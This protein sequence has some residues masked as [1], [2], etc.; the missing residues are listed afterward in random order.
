M[1]SQLGKDKRQDRAIIQ[2]QV[3]MLS[4]SDS[5]LDSDDGMTGPQEEWQQ[6][7]NM[8]IHG[9]SKSFFHEI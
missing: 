7:T 4:F 5:D 9:R 3:F 8:F 2:T 1:S 6:A